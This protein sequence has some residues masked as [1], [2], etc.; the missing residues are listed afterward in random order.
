MAQ[1][2]PSLALCGYY[3]LPTAFSLEY[4]TLL[5]HFS[6]SKT[7]EKIFILQNTGTNSIKWNYFAEKGLLIFDNKSICFSHL[8]CNNTW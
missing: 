8:Q 2:C 4:Y 7:L 3:E 1:S 6:K 5:F